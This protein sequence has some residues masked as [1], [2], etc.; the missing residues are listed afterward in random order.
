MKRT[1][2]LLLAL[3]LALLPG[4]AFADE[5]HWVQ[6]D[7][8]ELTAGSTTPMQGKFFTSLWGGSASDMDVQELLHG[9]NLVKWDSSL[10][11]VR[12]DHSVVAG[13]VVQDDHQGNRTY[14]LTLQD[15]LRYSDGSAVTAYDYA[16]SLL[17]QMD[18]VISQLGGR[19]GDYSWLLGSGEYLSGE[20]KALAGLRVIDS[21][22]L[23]IRVKAEALPCYFEMD[24]LNLKPYPIGQIAPG[25]EV[26]DDGQGAYLTQP[27]QAD[28]L[29]AAV[30][31]PEKGYL[32]HPQV[33]SGPYVLTGFDGTTADFEINPYYKG[34]E[35]G[36]VPRIQKLHYTLADNK[37]MISQLGQGRFGLLN[38]VAKGDAL[39]EG[40][41]LVET[42]GHQYTMC[43]YPRV[44]LMMLW[45]AGNTQTAADTAVREA[46]AW[47]LDREQFV[48]GYV[49]P[50]GHV[51]DVYCGLGHWTFSLADGA[52]QAVSEDGMNDTAE[53]DSAA[54]AWAQITLDGLTAYHLDIGKATGLLEKD[55]WTLDAGGNRYAGEGV[56][57]KETANG[58]KAL[59][60]TLGLPES[61]ETAEAF[62]AV[63]VPALEQAGFRVTLRQMPLELLQ[64]IYQGKAETEADL[65]YLGDNFNIAFDPDVFYT[66][67]GEGELARAH[68]KLHEM[69]LDM[70]RTAPGDLTGYMRKWVRLQEEIN[71]TLPLIPIYSNIYF[72]FYTRELYDYSLEDRVTWTQ[73]IVPAYID[74]PE[75]YD[76]AIDEKIEKDAKNLKQLFETKGDYWLWQKNH[77]VH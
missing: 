29:R 1:V 31:D 3:L 59:E 9:Y 54:Q 21:Q 49:G 5:S 62:E 65:I 76:E 15:D 33:V 53:T 37:D 44:G 23:Q 47:C 69:A 45:F 11:R 27:L 39:H 42:A 34:N 52:A 19:P 4:A 58:L 73:A 67:E 66:A 70:V 25:C 71:R 41:R 35:E 64:Q 68:R 7:Y 10:V 36:S 32:S 8:S 56:R 51:M 46:I 30:L 60:I 55:G 22:R 63:F 48:R 20:E 6:Y 38:K 43:N 77:Q 2:S 50:F 72:D 75:T 28:T 12:I 74:A 40:I 57:C 17:F 24:R 14:Y 26:K 18:P 16:F 61:Q 13:F